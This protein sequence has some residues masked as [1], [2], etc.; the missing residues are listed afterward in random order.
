MRA[1]LVHVRDPQFYAIPS[2]KRAKNGRIQV[3]GF[4]PIG[5]MS[6]SSVLK[7]AGHECVMFDQANP[8]TPN[9]VILKEILH[10][11]P[12]LVGLSFLSTTSYPHAKI[13][14]REIRAADSKVKIAFGGVFATLNA[15]LVKLQ[16][17]EVD[18]VCRG[19]GE[20]LILDLMERLD[21]PDT[22]S[23]VTWQEKNGRLRHNP[24]RPLARDLDQ[25][26]F[27]DREGLAFDFV[28]SMPLDVPAVL[29]LKRF[30]TMQTSRGCPWP[31]VFCDIPIFNEGKWRSRSPNHVVEE[32][33]QLQRDGYGAVYFVD[34]HFL[35][36]PKRIEAIYQGILE[37]G[38]TIEW[39]CEGRVDS[40]CMQL[41]PAMAKAHCRTL[42]FGIESGSQRVLDRLKKEQTLEEIE[43]AVN[44]AKRAGIEIVHGFFVVGS[45]DETEEDM[46]R[47]FR[48]A[49]KLR[50]DSFGFNRLCVYRG[51]PL[52]QE[53]VRRGLVND[54]RDWYK[55]FKCSSIDPTVLP[56]EV[57][58]RI[59]SEGLRYLILY[60]LFHYPVQVLRL[61]RRFV[62][63]MPL[64]DVIYL[65]VK[66][67]L[68][69]KRGFT[70]AEVISRA[71]EQEDLKSAAAEMTQLADEALA[72]AL[73][74]SRAERAR[75]QEVARAK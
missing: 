63:H 47:T 40:V 2:R 4:P 56:G 32:L 74:G 33:K 34:D 9:E 60:K 15:Q 45:P 52:W 23:G 38:I 48:F 66:P 65:I 68:G 46:R 18:F 22:V 25:W 14:A 57:I 54:A 64:R 17:P 62:R 75:L 67:F 41:F 6:L 11:K 8:E 51:T 24:N 1:F 26:P 7:R 37:S 13:L 50:I 29:S 39:G 30:T 70:K 49:A 58:H 53:Y 35:L 20:Q 73:R 10:Q 27:P 55:Y 16:C 44:N 59:R 43:T 28:E 61:L 3:M 71:V 42:M 31:C 72:L 36:Q 21:D 19:D 69:K 5:I 12:D